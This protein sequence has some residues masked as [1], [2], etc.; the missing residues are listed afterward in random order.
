MK[1]IFIFLLIF[2]LTACSKEALN[3]TQDYDNQDKLSG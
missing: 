2:I 1:K 3:I